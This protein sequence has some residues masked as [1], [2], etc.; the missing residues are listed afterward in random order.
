VT[1]EKERP[2]SCKVG[3]GNGG[4]GVDGLEDG[5]LWGAGEDTGVEGR[6]LSSRNRFREDRG[7]SRR[8]IKLVKKPERRPGRI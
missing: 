6:V 8:F 3:G 4:G 7:A 2:N 5:G 1:T